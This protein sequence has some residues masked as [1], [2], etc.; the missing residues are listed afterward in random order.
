MGWVGERARACGAVVIAASAVV[1]GSGCAATV[2]DA[3]DLHAAGSYSPL[4]AKEAAALSTDEAAVDVAESVVLGPQGWGPEFVA[5][6]GDAF[7]EDDLRLV[8]WRAAAD[9]RYGP[10]ALPPGT[11]ASVERTVDR[12]ADAGLW[13]VSSVTVHPGPLAAHAE[14]LLAEDAARRCP[15]RDVQPGYRLTGI[16]P[17][18]VAPFGGVGAVDEIVAESG[19]QDDGTERAYAFASGTVRVGVYVLSVT[20]SGGPAH[21]ADELRMYATKALW[22]MVQRLSARGMDEQAG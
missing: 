18:D 11:R 4:P 15:D 14:W 6:R 8:S 22:R 17:F 9:C 1:G 21:T 19:R 12:R 13:A 10:V 2:V 7:G 5:A 20:V 16:G 3:E